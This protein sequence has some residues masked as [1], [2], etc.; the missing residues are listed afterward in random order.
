MIIKKNGIKKISEEYITCHKKHPKTKSG[1]IK[2]GNDELA[3]ERIEEFNKEFKKVVIFF[4]FLF[5]YLFINT[6][7]KYSFCIYF[8]RRAFKRCI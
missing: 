1:I 7:E 6:L 8:F 4:K 3:K 2:T 5:F